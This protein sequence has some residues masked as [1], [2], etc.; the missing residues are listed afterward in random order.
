MIHFIQ[1]SGGGIKSMNSILVIDTGS[2][3]MRGILFDE[4]GSMLYIKQISYF[5]NIENLKAEQEPSD[6]KN[7]LFDIC[8]AVSLFLNENTIY[9]FSGIVLTSQRSSVIAVDSEG[10]PLQPALMWYD[11][12]SQYICGRINKSKKSLYE[13]CGILATPVMA[14]PKMALI[15]EQMPNIYDRS[16]KLITIHDYLLYLLTGR[17]VTDYSFAGRT[18]LFDISNL[19]W[20]DEMIDMFGLDVNKLCELCEPG[21]IVGSLLKSF[22]EQTG[23]PCVPVI[24]GGGDQ[25][26]AVLGQGLLEKGD[27]SINTGTGAY[28]ISVL[29]SPIFDSSGRVNLGYSAVPGKWILEAN[30]LSSGSVYKWFNSRFFPNA[31]PNDFKEIDGEVSV[32]PPGSNGVI[33][34]PDLAGKG[35]PDWDSSARG[36]FFGLSFASSRADCSRAVLEG[37]AA[38]ISECYNTLCQIIYGKNACNALNIR[39]TGGLSKS[40][41]FNQIIAD[42][43]GQQINRCRIKEST[44]AGAWINASVTLGF[45]ETREL[46]SKNAVTD[47]FIPLPNEESTYKK[48]LDVRKALESGMPNTALEQYS[49][50][51]SDTV[52]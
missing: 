7:A 47:K 21:S 19:R 17:F 31:E 15:K 6:F 46:A 26:C 39:S 24:T 45:F 5:M 25:Q 52:L 10:V 8:K 30:T 41:I 44:A 13:I 36:A 27:I 50:E 43:I 11:K 28:V 40:D 12:R 51:L 1:L 22:C 37:I 4:S 32:T 34:L 49:S 20:S 29:D 3:S 14:A 38:E 2:Q 35:C 18:C 33:M 9:K 48:L 23:L 16:F 42:M